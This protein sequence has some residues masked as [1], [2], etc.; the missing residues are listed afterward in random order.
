MIQNII[1]E[2]NEDG[3][4]YIVG[5][6]H[7]CWDQLQLQLKLVGFDKTK[8][9]LFSVGDLIDRGPDSEMVLTLLSEPWFFPVRGNHEEFMIDALLLREHPQFDVS[10]W[11]RNGGSWLESADLELMRRVA[12][13]LDTKVPLT[14][15]VLTKY[16]RLGICHAQPPCRNWKDCEDQ[17]LNDHQIATA[18]WSPSLIESNHMLWKCENVDLTLHGHTPVREYYKV[19]NALFVDTG[20]FMKEFGYNEY[21]GV[22]ILRIDDIIKSMGD[23]L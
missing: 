7:G 9:R 16:G 5:D 10:V 22:R 14:R 20:S 3:K 15:T 1:H 2:I 13:E 21:P 12:N 17:R 11:Y 4:D 19:G 18:L 23:R 8:D 6:I